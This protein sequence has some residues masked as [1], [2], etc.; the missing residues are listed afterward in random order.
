MRSDSTRMYLASRSYV[1]NQGWRSTCA[2]VML[3]TCRAEAEL[4]Q[5][6]S[7]LA[8]SRTLRI[9]SP[10]YRRAGNTVGKQSA[11]VIS[12]GELIRLQETA[13]GRWSPPFPQWR[14]RQP[15][16]PGLDMPQETW[17]P[18]QMKPRK[19]YPKL[20]SRLKL[21]QPRDDQPR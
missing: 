16:Q 10:G 15:G 6:A 21:N 7:Y 12:I 1:V 19:Q 4:F 13:D 8:R 3:H 2:Y 18:L 11:I 5:V 20:F 9:P 14:L 17:Q